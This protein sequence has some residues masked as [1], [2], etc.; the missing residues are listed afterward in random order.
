[1]M[2]EMYSF[3]CLYSTRKFLII[4]NS[5]RFN[6]GKRTCV[7]P[8]SNT[9]QSTGTPSW[10]I[11]FLSVSCGCICTEITSNQRHP[12]T[13]QTKMCLRI[14]F[15]GYKEVALLYLSWFFA[16]T[17]VYSPLKGTNTFSLKTFFK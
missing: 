1:M 17:S 7:S 2:S 13:S 16:P 5:F 14:L 10:L 11:P 15:C 6:L 4:R 3:L 8:E 9:G 12:R